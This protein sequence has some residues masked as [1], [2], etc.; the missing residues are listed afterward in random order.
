M[1]TFSKNLKRLRTTR[2]MTQE[3]AALALGVSPQTVSRWECASTQPDIAMLPAIAR[4]YGVTID[5][6][7]KEQSVA[8]QNDAQRLASIFESTLQPEEFIAADRAFRQLLRSG[9]PTNQDLRLYGILYQNMMY[10]CMGKARELFDRVL[11]AGPDADPAAYWSTRRQ[12]GYFLW[13]IGRNQENIDEFLPLVEGG[14]TQLQDWICLIQAYAFAEDYA[15]AWHWTQL[16]NKRFPENATLHI[17]TGDLLRAMKRYDE[18]FPHWHRARELEPDWLDAAWSM[19]ECHEELGR[20]EQAA[21][22]YDTIAAELTRLGFTEE[23]SL[24]RHKA[25]LCREKLTN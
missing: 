1:D 14:S 18:A 3:Q 5:D 10:V 15:S 23:L 13:E 24:P 8:Y 17:Y 19:A 6:L 9:T 16:A 2:S 12:K 7:Y 4:L 20:Y 25:N 11:Q 22:A 21:A